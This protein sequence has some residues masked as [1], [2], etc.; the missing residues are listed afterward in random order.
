MTSTAH[1]LL[2]QSIVQ[3]II[4]IKRLLWILECDWRSVKLWRSNV[5]SRHLYSLESFLQLVRTPSSGHFKPSLNYYSSN[6]FLSSFLLGYV[7]FHQLKTLDWLVDWSKKIQFDYGD[8][9]KHFRNHV[10]NAAATDRTLLYAIFALS[11]RH[12]VIYPTGT[13][14]SQKSASKNVSALSYALWM[15]MI[16]RL[17]KTFSHRP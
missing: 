13:L 5:I 15:T 9:Q 2:H 8:P 3:V 14:S 16:Q 4:H 12:W 11:S 10:S 1:H 17:K 6:I 7:P